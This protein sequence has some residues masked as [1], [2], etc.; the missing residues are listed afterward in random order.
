MTRKKKRPRTHRRQLQR[1]LDKLA[2]QRRKL[3][4]LEAGGHI[5]RPIEVAATS[6]IDGLV[7]GMRCAGCDEPV[8][9]EHETATVHAGRV[10]R[11]LRLKCRQC[12]ELRN[13]YF[14][15]RA[16]LN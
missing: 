15:V 8:R 16:L 2:A 4:A 1:K 13:A 5:D 10:T 11:S 3:Y 7:R 9:I 12:G 6:Q 14:A